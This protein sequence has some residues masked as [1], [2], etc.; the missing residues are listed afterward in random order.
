MQHD[1]F[2]AFAAAARRRKSA[3]RN[4]IN[5]TSRVPEKNTAQ[6]S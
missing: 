3:R 4:A 2:T 5:R 1:R 6:S